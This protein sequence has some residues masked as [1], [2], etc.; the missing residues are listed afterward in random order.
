MIKMPLFTTLMSQNYY[1]CVAVLAEMG[2]FGFKDQLGFVGL[3]M[4]S[5]LLEVTQHNRRCNHAKC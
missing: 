1:I 4:F 5:K 2:H 3:A